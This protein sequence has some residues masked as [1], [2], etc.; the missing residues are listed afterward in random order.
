MSRKKI[1]PVVLLLCTAFASVA[2]LTVANRPSARTTSQ[3]AASAPG[4]QAGR[5]L[6][7]VKDGEVISAAGSATTPQQEGVVQQPAVV[8]EYVVYWH[9]FHHI[10]VLNRQATEAESRGEDATVMRSYYQREAGLEETQN[11]TMSQI[12]ADTE[13][14]VTTIDAQARQVIAAYRA[15][16]PGGLMNQGETPPPPP[17]ELA[18]LQEQRNAAILHGRERLQAAFGATEFQ[19]FQGFVS[20]KVASQIRPE[21]MNS[22]RPAAQAGQP[23]QPQLMQSP[24]QPGTNQL[25]PNSLRR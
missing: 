24:V 12:A 7:L 25:Q 20:Q 17:A 9:L 10:N 11:V 18:G 6:H 5:S 19:R 8:P 4:Q 16:H 21:S 23:R 13:Q 15:A 22:L 2:A 14:A 1:V 3:P